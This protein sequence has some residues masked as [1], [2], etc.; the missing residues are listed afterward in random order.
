[1]TQ[2]EL[3]DHLVSLPLYQA[4]VQEVLPELSGGAAGGG[5]FQVVLVG[6]SD[7]RQASFEVAV[8]LCAATQEVAVVWLPNTLFRKDA[9]DD[10]GA[11]VTVH[12]YPK[13]DVTVSTSAVVHAAGT[14]AALILVLP[15]GQTTSGYRE[16]RIAITDEPGAVG[17]A[18][19]SLRALGPV[20]RL[21]A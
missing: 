4:L 20:R 14:K 5:D 16:V 15:D 3:C 17:K 21:A 7:V 13:H 18:V 8:L 2:A 12:V 11:E 1:M 10:D 9:V 19:Q 6:R